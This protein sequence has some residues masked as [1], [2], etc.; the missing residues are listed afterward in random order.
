MT[1][2]DAHEARWPYEPLP[3]NY[4]AGR[5]VLVTLERVGAE[6][7]RWEAY[8]RRGALRGMDTNPFVTGWRTDGDERS[9]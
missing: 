7:I 8:W 2:L 4:V 6:Q 9:T 1:K 3:P 5:R